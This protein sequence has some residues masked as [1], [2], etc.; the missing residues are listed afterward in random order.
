MWRAGRRI[1]WLDAGLATGVLCIALSVW[2]RTLVTPLQIAS[3]YRSSDEPGAPAANDSASG[4]AVGTTQL[5]SATLPARATDEG[6]ALAP[7]TQSAVQLPMS[8]VRARP[9]VA[10]PPASDVPATSEHAAAPAAA[11]PVADDT[12]PPPAAV[13]PTPGVATPLITTDEMLHVGLDDGNAAGLLNDAP[14]L[15]SSLPAGVVSDAASP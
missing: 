8:L 12:T 4:I 11:A 10:A 13:T 5:T 14:G 7:V 2:P 1:D 15:R 6:P 3:P 9:V